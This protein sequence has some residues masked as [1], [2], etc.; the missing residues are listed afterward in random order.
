MEYLEG[1][2]G[3]HSKTIYSLKGFERGFHLCFVH[4]ETHDISVSMQCVVSSQ[5]GWN[6]KFIFI[7]ISYRQLTLQYKIYI[8]FSFMDIRKGC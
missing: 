2:T 3:G 7:V 8:V 4:L 5:F 1:S 6:I